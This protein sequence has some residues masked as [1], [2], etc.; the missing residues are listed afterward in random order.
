MAQ[1]FLGVDVQDV[2]GNGLGEI[3]DVVVDV[4][5]GAIHYF[6]V[7]AGGF[8]GIGEKMI[9]VPP[10]AFSYAAEEDEFLTLKV[11]ADVLTN[12]P[13]FDPDDLPDART[14]GWDDEITSYWDQQDLEG[15]TGDTEDAAGMGT[16]TPTTAP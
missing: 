10:S 15:G 8:L 3:E 5:T 14:A 7:A 1:D 11:A 12:A 2:E 16:P 9:P 4:E 6:V 13:T